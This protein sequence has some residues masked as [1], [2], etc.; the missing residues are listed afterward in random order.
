ME[1]YSAVKRNKIG[2]F[3]EMQM[4]LDGHREKSQSEREKQIPYINISIYVEYK[5]GII[6]LFAKQKQRYRCGEQMFEHQ[7][8]KGDV[9]DELGS[10]D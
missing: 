1:Y 9:W 2:S 7:G 10:W 6:V 3:V 5:N 8:E 4:Y